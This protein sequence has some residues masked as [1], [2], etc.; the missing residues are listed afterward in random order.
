MFVPE[1]KNAN[2][3]PDVA[4]FTTVVPNEDAAAGHPER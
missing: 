2:P 1:H 3:F 4:Q